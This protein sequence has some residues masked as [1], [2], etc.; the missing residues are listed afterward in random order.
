MATEEDI[1]K[2]WEHPIEPHESTNLYKL[3]TVLHSENKRLDA[4]LDDLY[5]ERFL[6]TA[7]GKELEKIG[8][9]VG[10]NRKD[11]ESDEKLRVRIRAGFAAAASDSTYES[12]ASAVLS[13][14][15]ASPKAIDIK[16]PPETHPKVVEVEVDGAV[17]SESPLT[18]SELQVLLN[19]AV[20]VDAKVNI[21]KTGTFGFDGDDDSLEGF[22][23]GTWSVGI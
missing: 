20:S 21:T 4:N 11:Q 19:G 5:D 12:F 17:M 7:T 1:I 8:E 22:N 14:L 15:D 18:D 23:E 2:H 3:L 10:I 6:D 13:I 9:L 16:T